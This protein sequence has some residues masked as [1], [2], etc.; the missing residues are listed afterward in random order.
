MDLNKHLKKK[1]LGLIDGQDHQSGCW[2][3]LWLLS[4]DLLALVIIVVLRWTIL[5]FTT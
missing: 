4:A 5:P 1:A 3:L 2:P